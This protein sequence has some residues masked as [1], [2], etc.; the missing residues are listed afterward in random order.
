VAAAVKAMQAI[1]SIFMDFLGIIYEAT[2]IINPSTIYLITRLISSF[3]LN[4]S[5]LYIKE[6]E[7]KI[8]ER[9]KNKGKIKE[10]IN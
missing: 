9:K 7:K 8:K 1:S 10:Y 5:I 4:I 3:V 6:K 2:A